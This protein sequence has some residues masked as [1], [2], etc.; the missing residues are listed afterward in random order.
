[1]SHDGYR[2]DS[3]P[4][5]PLDLFEQARRLEVEARQ[6]YVEMTDGEATY[7]AAL[8][9]TEALIGT[10]ELIQ[11]RISEVYGELRAHAAACEAASP[12]DFM[13]DHQ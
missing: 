2:R 8:A 13:E 11:Q 12:T 9:R 3:D 1:M 5:D 4:A 10:A 7:R 6:H